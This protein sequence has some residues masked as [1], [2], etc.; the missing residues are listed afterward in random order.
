MRPHGH[1]E[2]GGGAPPIPT[3]GA[4]APAPAIRGAGAAP[5]TVGLA[6]RWSRSPNVV[7]RRTLQGVMVLPP[8]GAAVVLTGVVARVWE[9]LV[10][11]TSGEQL[12]QR[13]GGPAPEG[14]GAAQVAAALRDLRALGA[15]REMH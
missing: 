11:P 7:D 4:P 9:A 10:A 15:V 12:A 6:T 13:L 14:P 1:D 3:P 8:E 2:W 5:D